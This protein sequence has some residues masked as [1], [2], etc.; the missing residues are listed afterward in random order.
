[1]ELCAK[2]LSIVF[3]SSELEEVLRVSG[4]IAVLR[5]REKITELDGAA[6]NENDILHIIAKGERDGR[7]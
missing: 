2:G 1:M 5:D 7:N 6:A 3:I 4:R